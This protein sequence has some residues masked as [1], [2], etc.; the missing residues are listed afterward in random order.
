MAIKSEKG[1]KAAGKTDSASEKKSSAKPSPKPAKQDDD[2]DFDEE[3]E[4]PTPAKGK[5]SASKKKDEEDDDEI[6]NTPNNW[7]KRGVSCGVLIIKISR[8][9]ASISVLRG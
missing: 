8:I 5:A 4:V 1:K 3:E 2:D 6:D 9:P 7:E